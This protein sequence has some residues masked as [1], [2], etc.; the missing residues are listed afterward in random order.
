MELDET[1]FR[2]LTQF[3]EEELDFSVSYYNEEYLKRRIKSRI[4]RNDCIGVKDYLQCVK[5]DYEEQS[6]LLHSFSINVTGFFRNEK[7]WEKIQEI[8]RKETQGKDTFRVWS[9]GCADGREPY[10]IALLALT[11]PDIN[12]DAVEVVGTDINDRALAK[13]RKGIY[14]KTI[15]NDIENQLE[16]L[17]STEY[18]TWNG[19]DVEL[20]QDVKDLVTFEE[21][22]LIRNKPLHKYD[23]ILC[24]N[25]FIYLKREHEKDILETLTSATYN[26]GYVIIGKAETLPK[27]LNPLFD[28]IDSSL[29]VYKYTGRDQ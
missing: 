23:L 21:H 12:E 26:G 29:R 19:K 10:S 24:R 9:A 2:K 18:I 25:V 11:D 13:A 7:V 20:D 14:H 15:T 1:E 17:P 8:L 5:N 28:P 4:R 6:D 16:F 22:D 3:I 27:S